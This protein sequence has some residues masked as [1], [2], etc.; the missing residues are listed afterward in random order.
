MSRFIAIFW[1]GTRVRA[2]IRLT[3]QFVLVMGLQLALFKGMK[4]LFENPPKFSSESPLW[5]FAL[6]AVM[7]VHNG[8]NK[9]NLLGM[10]Q[11]DVL[12]L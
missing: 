3:A 6:M 7:M 11:H 4:S 8:A 10:V 1:D 5:F 12:T 9:E 2:L